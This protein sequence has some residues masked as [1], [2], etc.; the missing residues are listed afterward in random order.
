MFSLSVVLLAL[1]YGCS[2]EGDDVNSATDNGSMK[3]TFSSSSSGDSAFM[4]SV[5][6][7]MESAESSS[8][9]RGSGTTGVDG[10]EGSELNEEGSGASTDGAS[11]SGTSGTSDA[12]SQ[13]C[14][15]TQPEERADCETSQS[16]SCSYNEQTHCYCDA[17]WPYWQCDG[18]PAGGPVHG[19]DCSGYE[20]VRGTT[21]GACV[22]LPEKN[23]TWDC[24]GASFLD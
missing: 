23:P 7:S 13:T 14:P 16:F 19:N 17:G 10:S 18:C 15:E 21:C 6:S 9:D 24:S 22:C 1:I 8:T 2:Q 12:P 3:E 11:T 20:G 4:T 5:A